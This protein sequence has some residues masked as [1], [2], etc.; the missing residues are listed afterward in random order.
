MG[1]EKGFEMIPENLLSCALKLL[2]GKDFVSMIVL[3]CLLQLHFT[4][5]D[6][7]FL[8]KLFSQPI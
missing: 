2:M 8:R 3:K 6:T 1:L 7:F 4:K 5:L